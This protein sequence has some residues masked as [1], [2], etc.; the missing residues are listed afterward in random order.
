MRRE[1]FDY[2]RFLVQVLL[3][4]NIVIV[5][6]ASLAWPAEGPQPASKP[7]EYTG[8]TF[9]FGCKDIRVSRFDSKPAG[10]RPAVLFLHGADGGVGVEDLYCAEA[11]RLSNKGFVVF[12]VHY[13]DATAPEKPA[14]ISEL[15][16][17][18]VCGKAT[19]EDKPRVERYFDVWT[20][21]LSDAVRYVRKQPGVDGER[22]GIVGL[23]L[24]G[25]VGLSCAM[26]KELNIAAVV[27]GFGGLPE[28][29]RDAVKWLPPTLVVYGE[30]DRVVPV[31]EAKALELL[32]KTRQLPITVKSYP[33]GHVFLDDNGKFDIEAMGKAQRLTTEFLETHLKRP[34][35]SRLKVNE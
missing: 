31:A 26:Q 3:G 24:G 5:W 11:K 32:A 17:R 7:A 35:T 29:K 30:K 15:V 25:F 20:S 19:E 10:K 1:H 9:K 33:V 12:I 4:V 21:C 16:K 6:G 8:D 2:R 22:V 18:A 28:K 14:K 27:S 23:S 34:E 13:L